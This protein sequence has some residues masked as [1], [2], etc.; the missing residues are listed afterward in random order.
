MKPILVHLHLF[1]PDMWQEL[2][3]YLS[4]VFQYP[5]ELYITTVQPYPNIQADVLSLG[6]NAHYQVVAN[7]GFDVGPFI[8]IL[9]QVN[10]SDYSYIIK[11]HSKRDVA[12]GMRVNDYNVGLK[13]WREYL[14]SFIKHL[15]QC[16]E[17]FSQDTQLGMVADYHLIKTSEKD[18]LSSVQQTKHLL[19]KLNLPSDK[20]AYVAGTMF[21]C[22]AHL[23]KALQ[24]LNLTI[25]DFSIPDRNATTSL[26]HTLERFFGALI[27]AQNY[28]IKDCFTPTKTQT[29]AKI[30]LPLR[31]I[32]AFLIRPKVSKSG[33]LTIKF[34]KIPIYRKKLR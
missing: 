24:Q 34:C 18:D 14:L 5:Y 20:F 22:R 4:Q 1:Y 6:V 9:N 12:F 13:L 28:Q 17:S 32:C 33:I 10:L 15:P 25:D 11:L 2:K 30:S 23:F 8:H 19:T 7:R 31:K 29:L 27:L 3:A 26:A 16:I 21:M